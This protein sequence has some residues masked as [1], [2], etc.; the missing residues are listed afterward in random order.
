MDNRSSQYQPSGK[1]SS[2]HAEALRHYFGPKS[3]THR[4]EWASPQQLMDKLFAEPPSNYDTV[5][6]MWSLGFM[7]RSNGRDYDFIPPTASFWS[8][9]DR[10]AEA[11]AKFPRSVLVVGGSPRVWGVD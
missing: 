3:W 8:E 4:V 5:C 10:L 11:C 6:I 9:V 1:H 7:F 2:F